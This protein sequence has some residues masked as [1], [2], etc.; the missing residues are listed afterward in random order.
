[1]ENYTHRE[2]VAY[3]RVADS[4]GRHLGWFRSRPFGTDDAYPLRAGDRRLVD[5]F[6]G[7]A[8]DAGDS[9]FGTGNTWTGR[10]L[11]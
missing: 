6:T 5:R 4:M 3:W 8:T 1:M 11:C 2:R 9:P 10:L 7:V